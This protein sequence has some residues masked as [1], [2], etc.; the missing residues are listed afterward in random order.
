[1]EEHYWCIPKT[2]F[3]NGLPQDIK[4]AVVQPDAEDDTWG[5]PGSKFDADNFYIVDQVIE[6]ARLGKGVSIMRHIAGH[7]TKCNMNPHQPSE[8]MGSDDLPQAVRAHPV[9]IE[10]NQ[11]QAL[12]QPQVEEEEEEWKKRRRE[13]D[14]RGEG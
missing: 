10:V 12:D 6:R 1:M 3:P 2:N 13:R 4:E 5:V 7:S 8:A 9:I 14:G 11:P